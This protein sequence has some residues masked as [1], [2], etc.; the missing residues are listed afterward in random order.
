MTRE[1]TK[2]GLL[3]GLGF[4]IVFAVLLSHN[5]TGPS[6]TQPCRRSPWPVR[7]TALRR[8]ASPRCRY[9]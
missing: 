1:T 6:P 8:P 2:I 7:R 5:G 3:V 9:R 4:I